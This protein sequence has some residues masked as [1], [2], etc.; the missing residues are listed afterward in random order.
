[1]LKKILVPLD[2]SVMSEAVLPY[3]RTFAKSM[4]A[5]VILLRVVT[6]QIYENMPTRCRLCLS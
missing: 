3:V 6:S 1:M 4:D 5:E 2:G